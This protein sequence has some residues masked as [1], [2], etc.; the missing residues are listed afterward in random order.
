[1]YTKS[2]NLW[3]VK[4]LY[5]MMPLAEFFDLLH[6]WTGRSWFRPID[7]AFVL[8]LHRQDP[9]ASSPVLLGAALASHQLGRGHLCLDLDS[10]LTDPDGTL[11][12]P[13]GDGHPE[14]L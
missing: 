14:R 12:L 3:I 9:S 7:R 10:A 1:M 2:F 11:S 13:A 5:T 4:C 8:F 6:T